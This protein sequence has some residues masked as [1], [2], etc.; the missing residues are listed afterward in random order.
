MNSGTVNGASRSKKKKMV[1]CDKDDAGSRLAGTG[2]E[3]KTLDYLMHGCKYNRV[4]AL[5]GNRKTRLR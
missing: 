3:C 1:R 4:H 2:K 5:I